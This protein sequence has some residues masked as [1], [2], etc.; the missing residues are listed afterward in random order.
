MTTSASPSNGRHEEAIVKP[1]THY[2]ATICSNNEKKKWSEFLQT[3]LIFK[4]H[5]SS[6]TGFVG[7]C[8]KPVNICA[9]DDEK[10]L[11]DDKKVGKSVD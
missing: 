8:Y 2:F 3:L 9:D 10:V 1:A 6:P 7:G 5:I 4:F 11:T